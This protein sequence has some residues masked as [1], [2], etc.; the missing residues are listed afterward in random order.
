M[1]RMMISISTSDH[2]VDDCKTVIIVPVIAEHEPGYIKVLTASIDSGSKHEF[3]ALAQMAYYQIQ[4]DELNIELM[5]GEC[6]IV[7]GNEVETMDS[8]LV[9]Y[10]SQDGM[11]HVIAHHGVRFKK[12]LEVANRYCTRWVRL[13]I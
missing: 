3:Q 1:S 8:G 5:R 11:I 7:W 9:I 4:D 6:S 13:D 10:R 2:S 12:L